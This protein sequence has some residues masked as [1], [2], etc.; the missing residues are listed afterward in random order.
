M[1]KLENK[2]EQKEHKAFFSFYLYWD[3]IDT[4]LRK[5]QTY[6]IMIWPTHITK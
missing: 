1:E 3:V 6:S 2:D 5:F 4:A